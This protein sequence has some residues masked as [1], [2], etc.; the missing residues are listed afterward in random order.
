MAIGERAHLG[1]RCLN[2]FLLVHAS[3]R[4]KDWKENI[5]MLKQFEITT[6]LE[7][8][9]GHQIHPVQIYSFNELMANE[10]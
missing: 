2:P 4:V 10:L 5:P 1:L 8:L 6:Y 3:L 9:L 7:P